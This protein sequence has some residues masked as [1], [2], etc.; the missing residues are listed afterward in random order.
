MLHFKSLKLIYVCYFMDIFAKKFL[1]ISLE[2]YSFT[3]FI[4]Y[5]DITLVSVSFYLKKTP[6]N[7]LKIETQIYA[8]LNT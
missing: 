3:K 8:I 2:S 1:I 5:V 6:P 7:G 4:L